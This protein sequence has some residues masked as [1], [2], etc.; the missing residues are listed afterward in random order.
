MNLCEAVQQM[1][2]LDG[3]KR[4][5]WEDKDRCIS[6]VDILNKG[7]LVNIVDLYA[8]D[9]VVVNPSLSSIL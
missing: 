8:T 2:S 4:R 3:I 1:R 6:M 7:I 5:S 9:W